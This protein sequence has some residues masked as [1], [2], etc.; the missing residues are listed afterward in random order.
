ME[1]EKFIEVKQPQKT[2]HGAKIK[3]RFFRA[4]EKSIL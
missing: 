2:R 4:L 1:E 3:E